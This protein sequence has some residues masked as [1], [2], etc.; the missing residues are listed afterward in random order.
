M[1]LFSK[2]K[3]EPDL[4]LPQLP[5]L[6]DMGEHFQEIDNDYSKEAHELP[7]FPT[8]SIGDRFSR[9]TIKS[10]ISGDYEEDEEP[11]ITRKELIPKPQFNTPSKFFS[12]RA[13]EIPKFKD[14]PKNYGSGMQI[15]ETRPVFIRIDKFEESL[16]IFK[17]TKEKISEI[18][19]F[20]EETKMLKEKEESELT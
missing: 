6:P 1:G 8:S 15:K 12:G 10:A 14:S 18:E 5:E 2:K 4:S 7:S 16:K 20:L 17:E 3:P 13:S 19:K 9:E 11:E